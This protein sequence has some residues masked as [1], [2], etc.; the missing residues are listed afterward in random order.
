[1]AVLKRDLVPTGLVIGGGVGAKIPLVTIAV[2]THLMR[3]RYEEGR[4]RREEYGLRRRAGR[5]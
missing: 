1:V 5:R 2:T 4:I 3:E